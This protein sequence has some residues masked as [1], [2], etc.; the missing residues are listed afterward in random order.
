MS[1]PPPPP[2][3]PSPSAPPPPGPFGG[4]P[5]PAGAPWPGAPGAL[6][7]RPPALAG[8]AV[9][10]TILLA[11]TAL[12]AA[13]MAY[14]FFDRA[15]LVSN[16][17]I[18]FSDLAAIESAD[19]LV[20]VLT[21]LYLLLTVATA[22]VFIIWQYRHAV[23]ATRLGARLALGPGWAIGGWFIPLANLVLPALQMG[24]SARAS[25]PRRPGRVPPII[26]AWAVAYALGAI[27]TGVAGALRP[28]DSFSDGDLDDFATSDRIAA[29]G[30]LVL[31]L[32]G[33]LAIVLVRQLTAAQ[34]RAFERR[35]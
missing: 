11:I 35:A 19:D 18:D 8:L 30:S 17:T 27:L 5:H 1:L 31:A 32:A 14:A 7:R 25:D 26:P 6:D 22:V 29:V 15:G 20:A 9:A 16:D 13:G 33:V 34:Q 2:S 28:N 12:A 4:P 3:R 24:G 21:T 10:L 23:G